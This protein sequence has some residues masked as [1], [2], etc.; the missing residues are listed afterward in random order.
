MNRFLISTII[1]LC[2]GWLGLSGQNKPPL[3]VEQAVW[4]EVQP[5]VW[6]A[7]VGQPEAYDLL[8]AAGAAPKEDALEKMPSTFFPL[9]MDGIKATRTDGKTYLRFPLEE[10][11]QIYGFGLN[12][13]TVHRRG[14]I[15]RLH[16]DHY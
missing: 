7:R 5:G 11:E 16:V 13:K 14:S 6:R 2:A 1:L 8:K 15:L 12:F 3:P 9:P 4:T 10:K